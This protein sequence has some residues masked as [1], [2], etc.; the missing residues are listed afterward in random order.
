[1]KDVNDKL[2]FNIKEISDEIGIDEI[3][4]DEA[5]EIE[6]KLRQAGYMN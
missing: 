3:G 2:D 4:I 1:L 6:E 5:R